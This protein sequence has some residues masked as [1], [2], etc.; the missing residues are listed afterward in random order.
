MQRKLIDL[1]DFLEEEEKKQ[2]ESLT[3]EKIDFHKETS[4]LDVYLLGGEFLSAQNNL[5]AFAV[6]K[7]KT[8]FECDVRFVFTDFTTPEEALKCLSELIVNEL[9]M[10]DFEYFQLANYSKYSIENGQL[11]IKT[12]KLNSG[13]TD[14]MYNSFA[15][16]FIDLFETHTGFKLES[17]RYDFVDDSQINVRYNNPNASLG[18]DYEE[19]PEYYYPP[20]PQGISYE[21]VAPKKEEAPAP[22][23]AAGEA[24]PKE[25]KNSWAF[26]AKE[27]KKNF[28]DNGGEVKKF[29][30]KKNDDS[31]LFGRVRTGVPKLT[32]KEI[33]EAGLSGEKTVNFEGRLIRS[34]DDLRLSKSGKC[35]IANFM[36]IDK[37]GGVSCV[38]FLNPET[39]ADAFDKMF[40]KGGYAGFQGE[41]YD[42]RGEFGIKLSGIYEAEKPKGRK[43]VCDYK[44]VELHAHTKMSAQDAVIVPSDLMKTAAKFGHKACAVTDHGVV[45][46][47]PEV[48]NTSKKLKVGDT[49]EAFKPLLGV[50]GYVVDDGPTICYNLPYERPEKI[51]IGYIVSVALETTGEDSCSDSMKEIVLRKYH[52]KGYVSPKPYSEGETPESAR[53][54]SEKDI[55]RTLWNEGEFEYIMPP[56][57][58]ARGY[59]K[60]DY[61][62][63]FWSVTTMADG[64][65]NMTLGHTDDDIPVVPDEIEYEFVAEYRTLFTGDKWQGPGNEPVDSYFKAGEIVEFIGDG[66]LCGNDVFKALHFLRKAGYEINIEELEKRPYYR[67]KFLMPV[68]SVYDIRLQKGLETKLTYNSL[69]EEAESVV[70]EAIAYIKECGTTDPY[71]INEMVGHKSPDVLKSKE[72]TAYHIIII[73]RNNMGL[74]NMYR[75]ISESH[76]NYFY[77]RPRMPRS[78]IKYFS[79]S[80]IIGGACEQGEIYRGIYN[81]YK[82]LGKDYNATLESLKN[83]K[84]YSEMVK[85]YDYFE[86]QPLTNNMFM[87]REKPKKNDT[88]PFVPLDKTDVLNFNK[89]IVDLADYYGKPCCATCDAHFLNPE[90][91]MYRKHILMDLG[92]EDAEDQ[93]ALYFRTTEEMLDEFAYLGEDKAI[94]VVCT[95]PCKFADMCENGI[96]P[97]P[98]GSYPPMI[99][100]AARDVQDLTWT[101]AN[102]LYRHNGVLNEKVR[103]RLEKELKSIIGNGFAIMYYIAYRLVKKSNRDGYIVGSRGS[104]GSSLVATMCGISE[105]NPLEP[106]YRC[107]KCNFVEFGDPVK[108]GSGFDLPP[109]K[110]PHCD[111]D[112]VRDG[113]LIPFETFLGFYGDK[114]PDI[115]LNFSSEYQGH[116]HKYVE[117]LFGK[118]HT[119]RAGTI[120]AYAEKNAEAVGVKV[121]ATKIAARYDKTYDDVKKDPDFKRVI[122]EQVRHEYSKA[123]L[124]YMSEGIVGVKKTTGQHPGGIVVIPQEQDIYE[125]TPI[126]CPANDTECGIITTHFDFRAMHDTI[127]KLDILGHADPT[128]LR[129]LQV[130]T[131]VEVTT[132]PIPDPPVMGL[133]ESTDP[134]GFPLEATDAGSATLGLSELGTNMARGMIKETHPTRFFDLVQLMGLSHGTDV[135][136]GNAQVLIRDGICTLDSVIGCRDSIMSRLI[137]EWDM[138]NKD[139]F[140]IMENVRKGKVAK[141][142]VP[143]KWEK[144]KA[145][146]KEHNVPD[147]YIESCQKIK[148]MFPKAHAAA[149]SISTLRVAWFK[150]HYPEEYYCA[151]FS[152]RGDE[153]DAATMCLDQKVLT[154]RRKFLA[155]EMHRK[156]D[157]KTKSEFYLC[158]IVEEMF[159]RGITFAPID[160]NLSD[161]TKF[162]K[163]EKGVIRPPFNVIEKISDSIA[164]KIVKARDEAP[165][166][167]RDDLLTR[168][169]IGKSSLEVLANYGLLD[170][171]PESSQ[172]NIFDLLA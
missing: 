123:Q 124:L 36:V 60:E 52:L 103:E 155:E 146:M 23:D 66:Y 170:G 3:I 141:G 21:A 12:G 143:E 73:T 96:K 68:F 99:A 158:E 2:L 24:A 168:S 160:I 1:F 45:Q 27:Q 55:D 56:G 137:D 136:S 132:I 54:F 92:F 120:G 4:R 28:V 19:E 7:A 113:Q 140:D 107:P 131:G 144:W 112:M 172:V 125:F 138:P 161:A 128:V 39:E 154:E 50:E 91:G 94:E 164:E 13:E 82:Q 8:L 162:V 70:Q 44:R 106:H 117:Y 167:N 93:A 32:I 147:W 51:S 9:F 127:L 152:I 47:F 171:M 108:Y 15:G 65:E 48:F 104:V 134:L 116:A 41:P 142:D 121:A 71:V 157:P 90:D 135:W 87:T 72:C 109:K 115:D 102:Q 100:T 5:L 86:I 122:M 34:E 153:F 133:L 156:D 118:T 80:L 61:D 105:V 163:V 35:V 75:L 165:F 20:L 17:F 10:E 114:S 81:R 77:R 119:F 145:E 58:T 22:D 59:V 49:D 62:E 38:A 78:L 11:V 46:A 85:L 67:N 150:V 26:K 101:R 33:N 148:Y 129:M 126:Q 29:V 30:A 74:Y 97:F 40:A 139:A 64:V 83:D 18:N 63:K 149:Y 37:T 31:K 6:Y 69:E 14:I 95:N 84:D 110:C 166:A 79:S 169:G 89:L 76:V 111:V 42:N 57:E 16:C 159:H 88:E 53:E 25:D 151:F 43:E 98:D 130:L